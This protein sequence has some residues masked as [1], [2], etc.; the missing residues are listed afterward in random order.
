MGLS[1]HGQLILLFDE[2]V[3]VSASAL[4]WRITTQSE[5]L[6]DRTGHRASGQGPKH[7]PDDVG[8]LAELLV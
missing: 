4:R 1:T 8:S 5:S 7:V 3:S 6:G 2:R